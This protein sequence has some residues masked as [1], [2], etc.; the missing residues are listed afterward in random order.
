LLIGGGLLALV[1]P[2]LDVLELTILAAL[3]R[4]AAS[5]K[6][7]GWCHSERHEYL[8]VQNCHM[9]LTA[10]QSRAVSSQFLHPQQQSSG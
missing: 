7:C 1:R 6:T 5:A 8:G 4:R 3:S 9:A 10:T 2:A